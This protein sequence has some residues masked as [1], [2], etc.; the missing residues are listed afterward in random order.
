MARTYYITAPPSVAGAHIRYTPFEVRCLVAL[1]SIG[2][3]PRGFRRWL[4]LRW[5]LLFSSERV[6]RHV[7][8]CVY[9]QHYIA[10]RR[11]AR[12]TRRRQFATNQQCQ[13]RSA[14]IETLV[15]AALHSRAQQP[16]MRPHV[17]SR[18]ICQRHVR[19]RACLT[20][21]HVGWGCH[22]LRRTVSGNPNI[23]LH[24]SVIPAPPA[25]TAPPSRVLLRH[26]RRRLGYPRAHVGRP[27]FIGRFRGNPTVQVFQ[28]FQGARV[29]HEKM[30]ASRKKRNWQRRYRGAKQQPRLHRADASPKTFEA[31]VG[32]VPPAPCPDSPALQTAPLRCTNPLRRLRGAFRCV[33]T[34]A[35]S[36]TGL[37]SGA[38]KKQKQDVARLRP[39]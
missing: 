1:F 38:P 35:N 9:R 19:A 13:L 4:H 29:R 12:A 34:A 2:S 33:P 20:P 24:S 27:I 5:W 28:R 7:R 17:E 10:Q 21:M 22:W 30:A 32:T 36:E 25:G 6:I 37:R 23:T 3:Q 15:R 26:P 16:T 18:S 31:S 8:I 39:T 14:Q 11:H